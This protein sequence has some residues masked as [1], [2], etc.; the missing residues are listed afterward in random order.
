VPSRMTRII[1]GVALA[2]SVG[3]VAQ[4]PPTLP[5]ES[6]GACP[7]ECCTYR[8][9][10]VKADTAILTERRNTAP[11]L[12]T[13]RKGTRAMAVTGVV[14]TTSFGR[15]AVERETIL[16][17][18]AVRVRPGDEILLLHYLGEG[19]WKYWLRGKV[20][21]GFIPDRE[22]CA[23]N[24]APGRTL[25]AQCGVQED[26]PP[27]TAWWVKIRHPDGREGWT[28]QV[29]HFG[30]MDACGVPASRETGPQNRSQVPPDPRL[31]RT[32]AGS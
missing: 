7:F 20:D 9:W 24:S 28:R 19:F 2:V 23:R 22:N 11:T 31:N 16:G 3:L 6:W 30:N 8:E 25:Y 32:P 10:S 15:A 26:R 17:Q 12:F 18:D 27:E 13:V 14:V 29:D 1:T 21:E 4:A 5:V